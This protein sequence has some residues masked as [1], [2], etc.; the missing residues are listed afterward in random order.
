MKNII[1]KVVWNFRMTKT[2]YTGP[3]THESYTWQIFPDTGSRGPLHFLFLLQVDVA[4][5]R[6]GLFYS[7]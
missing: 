4:F 5:L 1:K 2:L 3:H 7:L 6:I